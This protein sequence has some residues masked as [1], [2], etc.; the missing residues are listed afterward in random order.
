MLL[1][2]KLIKGILT[3]QSDEEVGQEETLTYQTKRGGT[4][5]GTK[6]Q[7]GKSVNK[8]RIVSNNLLNRRKRWSV[9]KVHKL[10]KN[11]SRR[12]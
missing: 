10:F 2:G 5:R 8:N 3:Y 12:L 4:S 1:E 11:L 9:Y 6:V 7:C